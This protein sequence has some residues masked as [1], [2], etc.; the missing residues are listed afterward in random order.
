MTQLQPGDLITT[1]VPVS[2]AAIYV[3]DGMAVSAASEQ[4]GIVEIPLSQV[5]AHPTAHRVQP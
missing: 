3:G 2:H 4:L 5:G 1:N